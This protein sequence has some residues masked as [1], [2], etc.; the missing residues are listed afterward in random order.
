MIYKGCE[1]QTPI[2]RY[3]SSSSEED[4]QPIEVVANAAATFERSRLSREREDVLSPPSKKQRFM[5]TQNSEKSGHSPF[6]VSST[7][8]ESSKL[9]SPSVSSCTSGKRGKRRITTARP[10]TSN[11]GHYWCTTCWKNFTSCGS[12]RRHEQTVC[13]PQR[14]FECRMAELTPTD[15]YCGA[16]LGD[17]GC[18][19]L[20]IHCYKACQHKAQ[21]AR[22]FS[23][24]DQFQN[25]L[26]RIHNAVFTPIMESW[27]HPA[28][29]SNG[30]NDKRSRCGFCGKWFLT[31]EQRLDHIGNHY[32]SHNKFDRSKWQPAGEDE[33][34]DDIGDICEEKPKDASD[35]SNS[36][37]LTQQSARP[38][39]ILP[40]TN[41]VVP[42]A[43]EDKM[44]HNS[45]GLKEST[46]AR[47]SLNFIHPPLRRHFVIPPGSLHRHDTYSTSIGG[48]CKSDFVSCEI[49]LEQGNI[50]RLPL[51]DPWGFSY[52]L[53]P[54]CL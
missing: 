4:P 11:V 7:L 34:C 45:H 2:E 1:E 53:T 10:S 37:I 47:D 12:W 22:T 50:S 25:H 41:S 38:V 14:S 46:D 3:L 23:R 48:T 33:G 28:S 49:T 42:Q 17:S 54:S 20:F 21:E 32:R 39:E 43:S 35:E 31:W 15:A 27:V 24:R 16:C 6:S 36:A 8:Q 44:P 51:L 26:F 52:F 19:R 5:I 40:L 13:N 30:S 29:S 18:Q 9:S